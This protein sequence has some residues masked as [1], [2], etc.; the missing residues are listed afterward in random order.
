MIIAMHLRFSPHDALLTLTWC[1]LLSSEV[2]CVVLSLV[3]MC[4]Y[5]LFMLRYLMWV[6]LEIVGVA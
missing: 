2:L 6:S 3:Q 1:M 5:V 4:S